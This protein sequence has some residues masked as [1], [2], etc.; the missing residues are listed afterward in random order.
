MVRAAWCAGRFTVPIRLVGP[1]S[2]LGL[3][4]T[5][6]R[7]RAM[8]DETRKRSIASRP[9]GEVLQE[10]A[11]HQERAAE[12]YGKF[13]YVLVLGFKEDPSPL[14]SK[15]E[16]LGAVVLEVHMHESLGVVEHSRP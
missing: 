1:T 7:I 3:W 13:P 10:L 6:H 14:T 16:A 5:G 11:A 4:T 8:S 9:F 15:L 2:P 12:Q